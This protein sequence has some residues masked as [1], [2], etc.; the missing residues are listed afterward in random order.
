MTFKACISIQLCGLVLHAFYI[1]SGCEIQELAL[2]GFCFRAQS[3]LVTA[4]ATLRANHANHSLIEIR[5]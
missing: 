3:Y 5:A 4:T 1:L 2:H